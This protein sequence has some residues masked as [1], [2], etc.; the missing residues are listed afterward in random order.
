[1][2]WVIGAASQIG[3]AVGLSDVCVTFSDGSTRDCLQKI[4]P[5]TQFI[6]V[7]F[8]GSVAIG[9]S[10][11]DGICTW[12]GPIPEETA[13]IP[14][15][16]AQLFPPVAK[17][18]WESAN[19]SER[20]AQSHLLM[21]GAHP[22]SDGLPGYAI[23]YA[24]IFRSPD[25]APIAIP[26]GQVASIGSGSNVET[27]KKLL[28]EF[29]K[30]PLALLRGEEMNR[31]LGTILLEQIITDRVKK[32]P[33][34]GVSPHFH[35]CRVERGAIHVR[36]NDHKTYFPDNTT[37]DFV[38]PPVARTYQEFK[39]IVKTLALSAEGAVC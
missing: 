37:S 7:G 29:S 2:T 16:A 21:L 18:I 32:E 27:Y 10:M 6:A 5:V 1:M 35:I 30:N 24:Y 38:M 8:A 13:W 22:T 39:D 4:Y 36:P 3:Y 31:K 25:F 14:D 15:E 26:T 28:S 33:S 23:C 20:A 17:L 34:A 9:F 19:E 11:L 12:L